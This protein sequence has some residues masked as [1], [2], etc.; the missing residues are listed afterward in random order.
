MPATL[1]LAIFVFG[2]VLLLI[3]LIGG[4]FKLFGTEVS[5]T[6]GPRARIAAFVLGAVF[7]GLGLVGEKRWPLGGKEPEL[8]VHAGEPAA[9]RSEP[10]R[11]EP[12]ATPVEVAAKP[13]RAEPVPAPEPVNVSGMWRDETGTVYQVSQHGNIYDFDASNSFTGLSASGSGILQGQHWE[14]TFR[15]NAF[16]TGSGS[17]VL[18]ADGNQMTGS[19]RD[20]RFGVYSRTITRLR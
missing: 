2:A 13:V 5:G 19:F 4:A 8:A 6:I 3:G 20:T 10:V 7:I 12:V 14:S 15:T 11:A 9:P 18:S 17:G 16:S 1:T